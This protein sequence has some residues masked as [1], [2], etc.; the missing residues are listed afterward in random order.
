M[1]TALVLALPDFLM[2]FVL[3]SDATN[4]GIG[5]VLALEGSPLAY[6]SKVLCPKHIGLSIYE[7]EFL[8]ILMAV[9]K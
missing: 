6:L 1:A 3:K 5:I 4:E 7:K 8:T 9:S 2:T